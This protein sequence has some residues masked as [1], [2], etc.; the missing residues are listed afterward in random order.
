MRRGHSLLFFFVALLCFPAVA[1]TQAWSGIIAPSRAIDWTT[2]GFSGGVPSGSWTQC[3]S[4]IAAYNGTAATINKAIRSCG[5]NQ[6]VLLGPG[7]FN[8]TSPIDFGNGGQG[9]NNVVL[10]GSGANS[11]FLV[12]GRGGS[13]SISACNNGSTELIG[14]CGNGSSVFNQPTQYA[15]TTGFTQGSNQ[16]TLSGTSGIATVASGNPTLL[17]LE[18]DDDGYTGLPAAAESCNP[19]GGHLSCN[20]DNGN[21]YV[22]ADLYVNSPI[23]RGCSVSGADGN[24]G[25]AGSIFDHRFQYEITTATAVNSGTGIVTLS[26]PLRHP[27]WRRG[28]SPQVWLVNSP[29][30]NS[31]LENLSIDDAAQVASYSVALFN[32]YH[33]WVS[34]VRFINFHNWALGPYNVV[35]SI[36]QHNYFYNGGN[37][38]LSADPYGIRGLWTAS[39]LITNNIFQKVRSPI[40][41]DGPDS[42]SV[43]AY[44]FA[45]NDFFASDSMFLAFW[46]HSTGDD[47]QLFEGNVATA[48]AIDNIHGSHLGVTQ[49]R[50]FYTGW[51]SCGNGQCGTASLKDSGVAAMAYGYAAR[52]GNIVGNVLGTRGATTVYSSAVSPNVALSLGY[53]SGGSNPTVPVDPLVPATTLLWANWDNVTNA[54]RFCGNSSDTGWSTTCAGTSEVPTGAPAY[55]NAVPTLGDTGAGQGAMPASF[56]FSSKPAFFGSIPWPPIGPDVTGGNVGQCG[57]GTIPIPNTPLTGVAAISAGQCGAQ[58]ITKAWA[59]QVNANPA[60]NCALNVMG[61]PPDGSGGALSFNPSACYRGLSSSQGPNPPTNLVIVA[62]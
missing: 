1:H 30:M 8:L 50:N 34:G 49:F 62:N 18:Q 51:E 2:A 47:Y 41:F 58:G 53:G 35:H 36:F 24:P 10:R 22:C 23:I 29:L 27:N 20:V 12:F 59:G 9:K 14:I 45:V 11:T 43:I 16:I 32:A 54:A 38:D 52:Y 42:G 3:G 33:C 4:T 6:Y 25:G 19:I 37:G 13:Y 60:M 31:G 48:P 7:T 15:W 26:D 55:P 39:N 46:D 5:T 21:Y 44:N 61:M 40:V 56:V 28:Q 57:N 17:F